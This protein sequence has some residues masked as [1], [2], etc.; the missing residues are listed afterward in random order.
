MSEPDE[1]YEDSSELGESPLP[2][3]LER[4]P[5]DT[6]ERPRGTEFQR[7]VAEAI[8]STEFQDTWSH[9]IPLRRGGRQLHIS[10]DDSMRML[11]DN[12]AP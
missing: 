6:S 4:S 7:A 8:E 9:G 2:G 3:P 11:W 5:R 12:N 10:Y 1:Q